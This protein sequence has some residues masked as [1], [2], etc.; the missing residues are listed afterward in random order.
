MT[1]RD[2]ITRAEFARYREALIAKRKAGRELAQ[3]R[4]GARAAGGAVHDQTDAVTA[5]RLAA[6][7]IGHMTKQAAERRA[8]DMQDIER[9]RADAPEPAFRMHM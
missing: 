6:D 7:Q 1:Q 5:R 2:E 8:K 4:I 9:R 3:H